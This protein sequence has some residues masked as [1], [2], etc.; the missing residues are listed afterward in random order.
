MTTDGPSVAIRPQRPDDAEALV[1]VHLRSWRWAYTGLIADDYIDLLWSQRA[2]R[3]ERTRRT[4]A[5]AKPDERHW[6]A[7]RQGEVVGLAFAHTSADPDAEPGTADVG[8]IYLAPEAVGQ[9]LGRALFG[10][11]VEDLRARGFARATLWVLESNARARRFYEAAGWRPD[12]GSKV[13]E[14][15]G[16]SRHE[17]RYAVDWRSGAMT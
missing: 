1:D 8:A 3:V 2:E 12:G 13:E 10:Y 5:E 7:E 6:L 9:G 14:R 11:A 4:I 16:A 15:P 17:V